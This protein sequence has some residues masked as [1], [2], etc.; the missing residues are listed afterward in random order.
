MSFDLLIISLFLLPPVLWALSHGLFWCFCWCFCTV[1]NYFQD[2]FMQKAI[3]KLK[4][5]ERLAEE[6]EAA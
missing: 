4:R 3:A 2:R 1:E 5:L 6:K